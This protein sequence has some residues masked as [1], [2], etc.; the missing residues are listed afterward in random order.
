MQFTTSINSLFKQLAQSST[1][2]T[3]ACIKDDTLLH[4]THLLHV[5]GSIRQQLVQRGNIQVVCKGRPKFV[6]SWIIGGLSGS[7]RR[8]SLAFWARGHI[9]LGFHSITGL[10]W[11]SIRLYIPG[12]S[13]Y[14]FY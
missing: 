13:N 8:T 11:L 7:K 2:K 6:K 14:I 10:A 5:V 9:T 3:G 4:V 1:E 12:C